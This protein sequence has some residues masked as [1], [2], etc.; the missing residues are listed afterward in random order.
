MYLLNQK[1]PILTFSVLNEMLRKKLVLIKKNGLNQA[2]G[3]VK[4]RQAIDFDLVCNHLPSLV[5][6]DKYLSCRFAIY[7]YGILT[8]FYCLIP[9]FCDL[10]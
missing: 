9:F 8:A 3:S 5:L 2:T 7:R 10:L 4:G 1:L 6:L